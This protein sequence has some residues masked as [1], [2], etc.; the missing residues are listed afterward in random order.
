MADIAPWIQA[1]TPAQFFGPGYQMGASSQAQAIEAAL[2]AQRLAT[3]QQQSVLEHQA[4]QEA[5]NE[6]QRRTDMETQIQRE[7]IAQQ[8]RI[9]QQQ[10][11]INRA[12]HEAQIGIQRDRLKETQQAN[13]LKWMDEARMAQA[14]QGYQQAIA[15]GVP[16]E[17]AI[18]Q[19]LSMFKTASGLAPLAKQ[20][21]LPDA[22]E[23]WTPANPKTGAPGYFTDR[24]GNIHLDT[25]QAPEKSLQSSIDSWEQIRQKAYEALPA[26]Q[27]GAKTET[28]KIIK[29]AEDEIASLKRQQRG[30][31]EPKAPVAR[32]GWTQVGKFSARLKGSATGTTQ[33][34]A[35][36]P[37]AAAPPTVSRNTPPAAAPAAV[38]AAV[39]TVPPLADEG[40]TLRDRNQDRVLKLAGMVARSDPGK[41]AKE[42]ASSLASLLDLPLD[43]ELRKKVERL[44]DDIAEYSETE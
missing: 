26:A 13:M 20:A 2:A 10:L 37:R 12:Y 9:E 16:Y 14:R 6:A 38:P 41:S 15:G 22:M 30:E 8:A 40:P 19:N 25:R 4:Q 29:R 11:E 31:E 18:L 21:Q 44:F 35:S 23:G 5:L 28:E 32:E 27:K 1:A 3:Q 7:R 24:S 42:V 33:V 39:P 34:P 36:L 17:K 43:T